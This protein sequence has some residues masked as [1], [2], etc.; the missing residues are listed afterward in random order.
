MIMDFRRYIIVST[1]FS[2]GDGGIG[3]SAG[4]SICDD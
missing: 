1:V 3:K 4:V 2:H